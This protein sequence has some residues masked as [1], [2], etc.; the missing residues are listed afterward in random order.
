MLYR[1]LS[2]YGLLSI[3][4]ILSFALMLSVFIIS[5][6]V[7]YNKHKEVLSRSPFLTTLEEDAYDVNPAKIRGF[8]KPLILQLKHYADTHYY[9]YMKVNYLRLPN[10]HGEEWADDSAS[11]TTAICVPTYIWAHY[12]GSSGGYQLLFNG[13]QSSLTL[14]DDE[15][16][17]PETMLEALE[18]EGRGLGHELT[19]LFDDA[20]RDSHDGAP[21]ERGMRVGKFKI[22]GSYRQRFI[23]G[24]PT[25]VGFFDSTRLILPLSAVKKYKANIDRIGLHIHSPFQ[26][27][28]QKLCSEYGYMNLQLYN[29]YV[30]AMQDNSN[31]VLLKGII[32][33]AAYIILSINL[34]GAFANA[35]NKRSFEIGVKRAIGASPGQITLQFLFE[36][37]SVIGAN[38]L[39]ASIVSLIP[40]LGY[41][42]YM[43]LSKGVTWTIYLSSYSLVI[44]LVNCLMV[45]LV[46][47]LYF[48]YR[49]SKIE[50]ITLIKGS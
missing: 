4:I 36:G 11:P 27:R 9:Q 22:V 34:L 38:I 7:R 40:I 18:K 3:T 33:A 24:D 1:N 28:I 49:S 12:V 13:G 32:C 43:V 26:P 17:V 23:T 8:Y 16:I 45:C 37:I 46:A 50:V 10:I 30:R 35:L 31:A 14:H 42:L 29:D 39:L 48:S 20:E 41:K 25:K 2:T 5:D 44:Y 19:V 47:S 6:S 15:V 21:G